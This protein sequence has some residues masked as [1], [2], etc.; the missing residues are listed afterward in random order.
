MQGTKISTAHQ[1]DTFYIFPSLVPI[2]VS[3]AFR[4]LQGAHTA[5][6]SRA[7]YY[8]LSTYFGKKYVDRIIEKAA[9]EFTE[10][11]QKKN[12]L[13]TYESYWDFRDLPAKTLGNVISNKKEEIVRL[14]EEFRNSKEWYAKRGIPYKTGFLLHGPPGTGKTSLVKALA[15]HFK[16]DI[17]VLGEKQMSSASYLTKAA[18]G[19][20][21]GIILIEDVDSLFPTR[22]KKDKEVNI[23]TLLNFLDGVVEL[24][25]NIVILTTNDL[26]AIDPAIY[27]PGRIDHLV[28]L[29]L[30][31]SE[32]VSDYLR[33]FYEDK[34]F[35]TEVSGVPLA[36]VQKDCLSLSKLEVYKKYD[37]TNH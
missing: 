6:R 4:E 23:S 15:N 34:S 30:A 8:T 14:I 2:K 18:R 17:Y 28:K 25:D 10:A 27:R 9:R 22:D 13:Y 24:E 19:I 5:E 1:Q 3:K 35:M 12:K 31:T 29:D 16:L 20:S 37:I 36:D 32:E 21:K 26:K 11:K 7:H 33:M